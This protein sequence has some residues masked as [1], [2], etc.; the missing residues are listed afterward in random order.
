[1]RIY[2]VEIR[3]H[4]RFIAKQ[5]MSA[6]ALVQSHAALCDGGLIAEALG[7][8]CYAL[9]HRTNALLFSRFL[10]IR[11]NRFIGASYFK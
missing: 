8:V 3:T 11:R 7:V 5:H 4:C 1:M 6:A 2:R 10:I 9:R